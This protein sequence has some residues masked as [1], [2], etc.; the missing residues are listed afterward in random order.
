MRDKVCG[1]ALVRRSLNLSLVL[2]QS[3]DVAINERLIMKTDGAG[4]L[5]ALFIMGMR[6]VF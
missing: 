1:A 5:E 3:A 6:V 2:Q 4:N